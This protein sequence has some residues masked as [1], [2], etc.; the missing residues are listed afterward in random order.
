MF[1]DR[2]VGSDWDLSSRIY[3]PWFHWRKTRSR[4]ISPDLLVVAQHGRF[5]NMIRQI[6]LA[7]ASAEKLG[8]REVIVK[9]LPEFPPGT[10]VLDNGV[11]LTHDP[12]LRPRMIAR[13]GLVLGG[14]FFVKPRLPVDVA[15]ADFDVIGK[16]LG[17][18]A[19]LAPTAPLGESTLVVHFRSGD[20]FSDRPH[21][22]LGQPP[23]AFY[24]RVILEENPSHVVLVY[25]DRA[26]PVIDKVHQFLLEQG[27]SYSTTS[28]SFKDD[29]RT[30]LGARN[31]VTAHGTLAEALLLLSPHI[32]RWISFG[33]NPRLFFRR[34]E[35]ASTVSVFD[36]SGEYSK[37]IFNGNWTNSLSQRSLMMEFPG[38]KLEYRHSTPHP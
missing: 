24:E 34:R 4:N 11:A 22:A 26:N 12:L 27:V 25:E 8:V 3:R 33:E 21:G 18:I 17:A 13:P 6:T 23:L 20:A 36:P 37:E 29:L 32:H 10:W 15:T 30:L 28:G 38:A 35:L 9:S 7:I 1:A 31:L 2:R 14:D 16:S 5:G 19:G